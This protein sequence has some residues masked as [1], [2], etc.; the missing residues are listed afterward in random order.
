[1][2]PGTGDVQITF[3]QQ[4]KVSGALLVAT[5]QEV[6]LAD[7]LRAK[8]MFD[9][10]MIPILG[11]VE[12]M[13]YFVCDNCGKEHDIFSRGGAQR[14]ADRFNVPFLGEI[15]ITPA[16]REGG[17]KGVPILVQD[18]GSV[19]SK[20]FLQI[21]ARLAGQLSIA[22]ERARRQGPTIISTP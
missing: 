15:P 22:S 3:S 7:V 11:M 2:P 14:A 5:P 20:S 9:K 16:L 1:M 4:L 10:V 12:N 21:A 13:S 17:D 19:V 8:A 18:P 6:A